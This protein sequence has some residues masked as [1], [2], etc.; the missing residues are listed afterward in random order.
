M[1]QFEKFCKF[2]L[3]DIAE[4]YLHCDFLSGMQNNVVRDSK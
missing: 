4:I 2:T 1:K 3:D